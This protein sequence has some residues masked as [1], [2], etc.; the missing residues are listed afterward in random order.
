MDLL[1]SQRRKK[2]SVKRIIIAWKSHYKK[3]GKQ[4]DQKTWEEFLPSVFS[5]KVCWYLCVALDRITNS[6]FILV[7]FKFQKENGRSP[8]K[9]DTEALINR[10]A[11]YLSD[12]GI[13]N[14]S[15]LDDGLLREL[16]SLLDTEISP[17]AAIVG[18]ILAQD[19]LRTLSANELPI[20]NWFYF[21]GHDGKHNVLI[22][23]VWCRKN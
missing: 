5:F 15:L 4:Q 21:N 3:L 22:L 18:G 8:N 7:L 14:E 1:K 16:A 20:Q 12:M 23:G 10:K 6:C 19:I 17:V 2:K 11:Q 9:V 13:S